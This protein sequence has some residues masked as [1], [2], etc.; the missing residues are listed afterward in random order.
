MTNSTFGTTNLSR[1]RVLQYMGVAA[2]GVAGPLIVN[3]ITTSQKTGG[4]VGAAA[5]RPSL[6]VMV[7]LLVVGFI[8]NL[9]VRPVSEKFHEREGNDPYDTPGRTG[10]QLAGTMNRVE[11]KR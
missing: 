8:A 5:Y 11:D 9:L 2:A 6:L 1:R 3:L 4:A 7:G 10:G